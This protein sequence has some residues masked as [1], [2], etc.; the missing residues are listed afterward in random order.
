MRNRGMVFYGRTPVCSFRCIRI[1]TGPDA[2]R[3]RSDGASEKRH[4]SPAAHHDRECG[5]GLKFCLNFKNTILFCQS[6]KREETMTLLEWFGF[7][8]V[9]S[10]LGSFFWPAAFCRSSGTS[11]ALSFIDSFARMGKYN[12]RSNRLFLF[13]NSL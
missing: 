3:F 4:L 12:M 10:I 13:Y 7:L 1:S 5:A 6:R 8:G 2:P 11:G 9:V